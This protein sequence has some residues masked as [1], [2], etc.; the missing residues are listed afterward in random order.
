[1]AREQRG[2]CFKI[3]V[4]KSCSCFLHSPRSHI[5]DVL[6]NSEPDPRRQFSHCFWSAFLDFREMR[7][8]IESAKTYHPKHTRKGP[9][10]GHMGLDVRLDVRTTTVTPRKRLGTWTYETRLTRIYEVVVVPDIRATTFS[11]MSTSDWNFGS[12]YLC[13]LIHI[14]LTIA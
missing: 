4:K 10:F 12:A 14:S 11:Y 9:V 1:M 3:W 13:F 7:F 2:V 6:W 8:R 5:G